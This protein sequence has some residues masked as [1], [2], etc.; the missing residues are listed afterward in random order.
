M[1]IKYGRAYPIVQSLKWFMIAL[2]IEAFVIVAV[3]GYKTNNDIRNNEKLYF[4]GLLIIPFLFGLNAYFRANDEENKKSSVFS[5]DFPRAGKTHKIAIS[6]SALWILA[7]SLF[8]FVFDPYNGY[9]RETEWKRA[10]FV[11]LTPA[12]L[13]MIGFGLYK[14]INNDEDK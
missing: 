9:W 13:I 3:L 6:M 10:S 2:A 11:I 5:I 8:F 4:F 12:A 1:E 7:S 14:W